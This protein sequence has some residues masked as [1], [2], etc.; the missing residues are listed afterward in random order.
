L[1]KKQREVEKLDEQ[2][3]VSEMTLIEQT[4]QFCKSLVQTKG[5]EKKEEKKEVEHQLKAGEEV[6]L[7]KDQREEEFYFAPTKGKKS[8]SKSKGSSAPSGKSIKHNAATFSLFDQLKLDAPLTNDEVPALLEKLE[9]Q[10]EEYKGKVKEWEEKR[11]DM[12]KAILE[13]LAD[14]DEKKEAA[15]DAAKEEEKADE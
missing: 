8:K 11:E 10:L 5:E 15:E 6:L 3:Y 2:P 12:K 4:I 7:R 13:G 9:A 1:K 14:L